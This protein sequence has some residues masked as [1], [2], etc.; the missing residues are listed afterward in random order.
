MW[1]GGDVPGTTG[2]RARSERLGVVE[3]IGNDH[4]Y[5]FVRER[6]ARFACK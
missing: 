6:T 5:E 2:Q 3:E 1:S 4:F